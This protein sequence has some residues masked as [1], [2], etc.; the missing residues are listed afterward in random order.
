MEKEGLIP[1]KEEHSSDPVHGMWLYAL[2]P[3]PHPGGNHVR[4]GVRGQNH[5]RMRPNTFPLPELNH[6]FNQLSGSISSPRTSLCIS[7][8]ISSLIGP[9]SQACQTRNPRGPE[10]SGITFLSLWPRKSYGKAPNWLRLR[11][12]VTTN[13]KKLENF[14]Q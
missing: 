1:C 2:E 8:F 5:E 13:G 12:V 3:W 14:N 10:G 9:T 6:P 4:L 7:K 11:N